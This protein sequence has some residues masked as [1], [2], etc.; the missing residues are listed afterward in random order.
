MGQRLRPTLRQQS[1]PSSSFPLSA[2]SCSGESLFLFLSYGAITYLIYLF[3]VSCFLSG[4]CCLHV[5]HLTRHG[6]LIG[7]VACAV[8]RCDSCISSASSLVIAGTGYPT[9][10]L[11]LRGLLKR[12]CMVYRGP[13]VATSPSTPVCV[14]GYAPMVSVYGHLNSRR[15]LRQ[16]PQVQQTGS[17]SSASCDSQARL[18]GRSLPLVN[19]TLS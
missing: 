5:G 1:S 6:F 10:G 8:C 15:A 18:L 4:L 11:I 13:H 16:C 14:G 19:A 2:G 3:F 9:L 17:S 12:A 7:C